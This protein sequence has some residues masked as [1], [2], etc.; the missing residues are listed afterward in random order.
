MGEYVAM[1]R[2]R[3]S[4]IRVS[5]PFSLAAAVEALDLIA[6]H[7][8]DGGSYEGWHVI[9]ARP[10]NIRVRQAGAR[11][12]V[13]S[14]AGDVV[15]RSDVEGAE[16]LVRRMF[17]LDLD[18]ERFYAEAA[19]DDRVLRRLQTRLL[20][21]RPVTAPNPLAALVFGILSDDYGPERARVV[22]GRLA[23]AEDANGLA[24][25]DHGV[26]AARLG[27][28]P[29]TVE[30]LRLIGERGQS[31]AFGAELLRSM[32]VEAARTWI[33]THAE[34]GAGAADVVLVAGAGRR[35]VFPKA[36]PQLL[37]AL[38]RYYGFARGEARRRL[39]ELGQRW[40][41]FAT[42]AAYLLVEAARRDARAAATAAG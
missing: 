24:R 14:V 27:I 12:L 8:G 1:R 6:P 31:G 23:G 20:G 42:W 11:Q 25:L 28:D 4:T 21:V 13:L 30:R 40:G 15:E 16:E 39:D 22:L 32:P 5:G 37:A 29:A 9:G 34:V 35:D 26:D 36:S 38:E 17:G 3:T 10:L 2:V 18:A 19:L 7:R 33:C 41:E